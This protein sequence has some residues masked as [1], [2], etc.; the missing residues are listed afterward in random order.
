[1]SSHDFIIAGA[2]IVGLAT[3]REIL[4][5]NPSASILILEKEDRPGAHAS[6]RNSGVLHSGIYY[7]PGTLKAQ[8]C[9]QGALRMMEFAREHGIA[10]RQDGKVITATEEHETAVLDRLMG[11]AEAN[12]I[13]AER[14]DAAGVRRL[15]PHAAGLAG[16][17]C[18]ET[19]VIDSPAVVRKLAELLLA[20]GVQVKFGEPVIGLV[21]ESGE[22]RTRKNMYTCASFINAAGAYADRVARL[23]GLSEDYVLVPFKGLYYKLAPAKADW[24]RS[25]LYPVP[26]PDMPFLG[27]HFTK[28]V[29][30]DVYIGPTAIP[31]LGREN[32]GILKGIH[33]QETFE[34]AVQLTRMLLAPEPMFRRLAAQEISSYLKSVYLTR[35]RKLVPGICG[36]DLLSC[37]KVGIRPQLVH[38]RTLSLEMD[39]VLQKRGRT[40]HVLNAISPAFTSAFAFAEKI[41]SEAGG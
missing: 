31:A 40:L 39:F 28:V 29:S 36:A 32:Y 33:A 27:V 34:I 15:E 41:V 23:A 20:R 26:D 11:Y 13:R 4:L 1:M 24:I 14:L 30:G 25:N 3:A 10:F 22:V 35:A 37:H 6:G 21:P 8:M 19:A 2:G 38:R 16:I 9:R 7:K 18:P 17:Y 5:R 12:G